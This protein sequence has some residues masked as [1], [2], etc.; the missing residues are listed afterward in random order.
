M[1]PPSPPS[2]AAKDEDDEDDT[3]NAP[4]ASRPSESRAYAPAS[5]ETDGLAA[6]G[7]RWQ[8][9]RPICSV[10]EDLH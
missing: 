3:M 5:D 8:Q 4:D 7:F 9:E 1:E 2:A 10:F 6:G